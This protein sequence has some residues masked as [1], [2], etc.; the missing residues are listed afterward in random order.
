MLTIPRQQWLKMVAE[1]WRVYP[2]EACGLLLGS[3]DAQLSCAVVERFV[4]I[5][6][7]AASAKLYALDG[8]QFSKA[9]LAADR[10]GLDIVG[11]VHSHTH[12]RA[13]PSPTDVSEGTRPLIPPEW[14]WPILSL[15]GGFP[16]L[17]SFQFDQKSD[18]KSTNSVGIVEERVALTQ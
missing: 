10:D 3:N 15:A 16:E 6:N 7:A 2:L 5:D 14:H 9:A 8:S 1:A 12:T 17:R 13:Y 11:V 4:A 18:D